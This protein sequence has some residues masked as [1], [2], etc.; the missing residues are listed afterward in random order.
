MRLSLKAALAPMA[1]EQARSSEN[2]KDIELA[3]DVVRISVMAI[4]FLAPLGAIIMMVT[5]PMLLNKITAEEERRKRQMSYVK[6]V[7][8]QP[9]FRRK[10]GVENENIS[11]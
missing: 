4:V 7:N 8:L 6:I 10:N 3:F 11:M 5:G 1:M 9:A 2:P